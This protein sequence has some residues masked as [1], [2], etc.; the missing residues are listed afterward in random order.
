MTKDEPNGVL[1]AGL[2]LKDAARY[3]GLAP[4]T[5]R[6]LVNRGELQAVRSVRHLLFS[7]RILDAFLAGEK[8]PRPNEHKE[9][10]K[11]AKTS[12]I[13]LAQASS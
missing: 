4:I 6:R 10:K 2:K 13:R 1:P 3:I 7:R 9:H 12:R 8:Q 5:V 11:H